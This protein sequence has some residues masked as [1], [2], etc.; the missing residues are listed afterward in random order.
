M[1]YLS[2]INKVMVTM[3]KKTSITQKLMTNRLW[4][5]TAFLVVWLDPLALRL[6]N[7]C[8]T[9][10]HCYACPLATFACPVGILVNFSALH[11][12]PFM[13]IG[14]LILAGAVFG[15]FICGYACP[16][17]L[18]QD[19]AA[20]I[21]VRK[22][23]LPEWVNYS[24]YFVLVGLVLAIPYFVGENHPL[25]FCKICPVGALEGA[26][27]NMISQ[28]AAGQVIAFPNTLKICVFIITIAGMLFVYRFWCKLCPLGAIFGMFNRV[29][30]FFLKVNPAACTHCQ[31][32][33]TNCKIGAKPDIQTNNHSCVRCLDCTQCKPEAINVSTIFEKPKEN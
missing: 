16:F 21:P 30:V 9:V 19:L 33:H 26:M 5:Q 22:F 10:F 32:C 18:L 4:I 31:I 24:R 15:G 27:P 23:S 7:I 12:F 25:A 29:S 17:G 3:A 1:P 8:G 28:A 20:K 14:T 13:A 11:L 2:K 6:H